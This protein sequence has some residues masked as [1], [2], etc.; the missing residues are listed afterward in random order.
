MDTEKPLG[1]LADMDLVVLAQK[2]GRRAFEELMTRY[3]QEAYRIAYDFTRDREEAKDLSQEAFL[4]AYTHLKR[5]NTRSGFHTWFYRILANLCVDYLRSRNRKTMESL[6]EKTDTGLARHEIIDVSSSPD[7]SATANELS[8][9]MAETLK[10]LPPRQRS[11]YI[12]KEQGL[13]IGKISKATKMTE[14]AVRVNLHRA[15]AALK[16]TLNRYLSGG[17]K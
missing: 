1:R 12:L 13:P 2:G 4:R 3:Q 14:G 5:F 16:G 10:A 6:D 8:V 9:R 11:A 7:G 17:G 15:M